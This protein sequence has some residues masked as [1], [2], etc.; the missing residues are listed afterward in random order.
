MSYRSTL[1]VIKGCVMLLVT[2]CSRRDD[3]VTGL[4]FGASAV[5]A[6]GIKPSGTV[7]VMS[8]LE[9]NPQ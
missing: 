4:P 5:A 9:H 2:G 1:V 7:A 8:A 3:D 6:T